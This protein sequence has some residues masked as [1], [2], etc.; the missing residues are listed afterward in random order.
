MLVA[1]AGSRQHDSGETGIG[2][3]DG[4]SRGNEFGVSGRQSERRIDAG[5]QIE[6]GGTRRRVVG[7]LLAQARIEDPDV[8]FP[9]NQIKP[10][11][12]PSPPRK[13]DA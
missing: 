3:M 12:P 13:N 6:P 10:P 9:H 2:E 4:D 1:Q 7:Q 8:D 5:A 11:R